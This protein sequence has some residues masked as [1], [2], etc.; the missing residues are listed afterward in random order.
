MTLLC[1]KMKE[2]KKNAIA[3]LKKAVHSAC[4]FRN[5]RPNGMCV[6]RLWHDGYV[7]Q[8]CVIEK[9]KKETIFVF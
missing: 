3:P 1:Y 4:T 5:P 6:L 9:T 8:N 7:K 2:E